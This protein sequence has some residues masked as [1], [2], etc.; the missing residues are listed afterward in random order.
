MKLSTNLIFQLLGTIVQFLNMASSMVPPKLQPYVAL[1]TALIQGIVAW[2][3][4]YFNTDG[5]VQEV[6]K[7]S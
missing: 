2:R 6:A 4:H 7:I 3:A 1:A 5:T